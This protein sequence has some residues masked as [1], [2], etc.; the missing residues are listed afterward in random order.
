[1]RGAT[2]HGCLWASHCG[3][4][5]CCGAWALECLGFSSCS[6][7]ARLLQLV[8]PRVRVQLWGM[9]L[10]ALRHVGSFWIRDQTCVPCI[11]RQIPNHW[12]PGKSPMVF[13]IGKKSRYKWTPAVQTCVVEESPVHHGGQKHC[14]SK[15]L[16][17]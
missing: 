9:A 17:P 1:M 13:F 7:W 11:G 12:T 16:K 10:V 3:G 6:I 8:G 2:L 14:S 4:F 5:S 15:R